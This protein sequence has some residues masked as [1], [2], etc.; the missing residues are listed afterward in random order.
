MMYRVPP[1]R[2]IVGESGINT[3]QDITR[4][5]RAG[6]RGFLVGES[7]LKQSD[8]GAALRQLRCGTRS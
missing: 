6:A 3:P 2:F 5:K 8:A 1:E 4:M 7:L